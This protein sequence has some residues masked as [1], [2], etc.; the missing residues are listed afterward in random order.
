MKRIKKVMVAMLLLSGVLIGSGKTITTTKAAT[1][2]K[3]SG[4]YNYCIAS[5]EAGVKTKVV[6]GTQA[7]HTK[8]YTT[9]LSVTKSATYTQSASASITATANWTVASISS[10]FGV[11]N[12]QS[13]SYSA[14]VAY[15]VPSSKATGWYRIVTRFPGKNL[16]YRLFKGDTFISKIKQIDYVPSKGKQYMDLQKYQ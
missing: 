9:Q 1:S 11:A 4:G 3:L 7:K 14:G 6:T 5:G 15:T 13:K 16:I 2:C 12:S 8:G 10:T